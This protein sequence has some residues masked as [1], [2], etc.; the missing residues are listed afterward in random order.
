MAWND[1]E[2]YLLEDWSKTELLLYLRMDKTKLCEDAGWDG[3][4]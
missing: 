4:G 1:F 3:L 2:N